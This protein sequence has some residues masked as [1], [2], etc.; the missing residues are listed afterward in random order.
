MSRSIEWVREQH[1]NAEQAAIDILDAAR[2]R[3]QRDERG[4]VVDAEWPAY[5]TL[6]HAATILWRRGQR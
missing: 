6:H 3:L 1:A 2:A 5:L 4:I